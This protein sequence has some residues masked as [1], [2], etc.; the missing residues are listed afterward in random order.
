MNLIRKA[1]QFKI[2]EESGGMSIEK[3]ELVTI[4]RICAELMKEKI[5]KMVEERIKPHL[6]TVD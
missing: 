2:K 6:G 5:G 3:G 4:T 1:V